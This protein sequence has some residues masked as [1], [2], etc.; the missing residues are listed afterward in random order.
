MSLVTV[1]EKDQIQKL[2]SGYRKI[3]EVFELNWILVELN[4]NE[5]ADT[6]KW[7]SEK[8]VYWKYFF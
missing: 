7:T 1:W 3:L 2:V 5:I 6:Q 8:F 4:W